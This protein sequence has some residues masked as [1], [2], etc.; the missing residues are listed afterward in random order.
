MMGGLLARVVAWFERRS[1]RRTFLTVQRS[2]GFTIIEV[3]V[4]LAV[5]GALFVSA[6]ILIAGRRAQTEFNQS[7][8]QIH[9]QLQQTINDVATGFFPS[10]NAF[11]CT[12][13]PSGPV[14]TGGSAD[15]GTN[16]GCIFLGKAMQFKVAG[17]DPEQFATYTVTGLRR[18]TTGNE[19]TNLTQARPKAVAPTSTESLPDLTV[20]QPLLGGLRVVNMWY[21]NGAGNRPIGVVA[22]TNSLA[23]Y[24]GG[25]IVSGAQQVNVV[26]V[27]DGSTDSALNR[28]RQ[29]AADAIQ[30]SLA[31][32]PLN[33]TGGVYICFRS[34]GTKQSGLITIG[35]SSR[36]LSVTLTLKSNTDCS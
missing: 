30:N 33:P 20:A 27:D 2:R 12:A 9:S 25:A 34:G 26:P 31:S 10:G 13:G 19:V 35:N 21:N 23:Q 29:E 8:R 32:S 24:T 28:T 18:T 1:H 4:V 16:A 3:M 17:T 5:T 22:F 7:I 14:I 6:A 36:Q 11:T 15:Q